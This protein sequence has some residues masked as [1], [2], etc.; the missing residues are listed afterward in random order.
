MRSHRKA[1]WQGVLVALAI[2]AAFMMFGTHGIV[3]ADQIPSGWSADQMKPI[4][5]SDLDGRG[6]AFKMAIK[7]ANGR[8]FL[9]MGHLWHRGWSIVEVTDP[10]NPKLVKFIP[11]PDNTFTIQVDLHDNLMLTAVQR[12]IPGWTDDPKK[13]FEEGVLLWDISDPVNPRQLAHWK[14]GG[15]GTHRN[16]YPGGQ[17]AYLAAG[18]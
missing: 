12:I 18:M 16:S 1:V 14:T 7:E 13:P 2:L 17:Y 4:G 15:G 5:Y 10:A 6:G 8:W 9:Y 11:G 3:Q